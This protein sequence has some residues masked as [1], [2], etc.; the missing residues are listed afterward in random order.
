LDL[1]LIL[2]ILPTQ[3]TEK[4]TSWR[5]INLVNPQKVEVQSRQILIIR[6]HTSVSE[7]THMA[8]KSPIG[9]ESN[10]KETQNCCEQ[11]GHND[12]CYTPEH[13]KWTPMTMQH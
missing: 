2:R 6:E 13:H 11:P 9:A 7:D 1:P 4:I 3:R 10:S 12:D 5:P 8:K